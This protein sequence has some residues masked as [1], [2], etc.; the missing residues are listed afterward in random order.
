MNRAGRYKNWIVHPKYAYLLMGKTRF[1]LQKNRDKMTTVF[2]IEAYT[3][4]LEAN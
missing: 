3:T 4:S 2:I 1:L